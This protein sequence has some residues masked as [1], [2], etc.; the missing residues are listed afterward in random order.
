MHQEQLE[1]NAVFKSAIEQMDNN[2]PFSVLLATI[3]MTSKCSKLKWNNNHEAVSLKSLEHFGVI[4]MVDKSKDHGK[5]LS[6][7][8][9]NTIDSFWRPFLLRLLRKWQPLRHHHVIS[10][11]CTLIDSNSQPISAL[12]ISQFL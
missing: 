1:G 2:F 3:E 6:I 7:C 8:C 12:E 10:M 4:S 11:V 9:Y 5:L